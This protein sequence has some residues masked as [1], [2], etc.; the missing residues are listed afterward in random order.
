[1]Q[2]T[3]NFDISSYNHNTYGGPKSF[4]LRKRVEEK[5]MYKFTYE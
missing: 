3:H 1:M 5:Y 4:E 2:M